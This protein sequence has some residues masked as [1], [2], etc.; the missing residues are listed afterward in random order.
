MERG[1]G[2]P[3]GCLGGGGPM[4][5]LGDGEDFGT[6]LSWICATAGAGIFGGGGPIGT[7]A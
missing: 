5:C 6:E 4:G 1:G 3:M 7:G 2:G